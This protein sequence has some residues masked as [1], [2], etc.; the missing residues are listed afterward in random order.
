MQSFWKVPSGDDDFDLA[1]R[2]D[3]AER[4]RKYLPLPLA[5]A[6]TISKDDVGHEV[7]NIEANGNLD[8]GN[9]DTGD[10]DDEYYKQFEE[11]R[12]SRCVSAL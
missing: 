10:S 5:G 11:Q 12:A 9:G 2:N 6:G 3:A 7:D 1:K 8:M 4:L